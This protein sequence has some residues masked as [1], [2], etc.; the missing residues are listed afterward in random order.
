LHYRI[1]KQSC[2]KWGYFKA[3]LYNESLNLKKMNIILFGLL[4]KC[5]IN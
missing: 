2:C 3:C 4:T 1:A 5:K